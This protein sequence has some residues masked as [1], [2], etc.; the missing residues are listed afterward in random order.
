MK[1][2]TA[3]LKK[4]ERVA[5]I[6]DTVKGGENIYVLPVDVVFSSLTN[7]DKEKYFK[8]WCR[9]I[10]TECICNKRRG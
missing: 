9:K 10:P 7:T 4:N 3:R 8:V 6:K 2:Y 1:C 5:I